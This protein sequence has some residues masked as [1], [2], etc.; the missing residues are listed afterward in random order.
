MRIDFFQPVLG[1]DVEFFLKKNNSLIGSEKFISGDKLSTGGGNFI[2][3]GVQIEIN[4]NPSYCR[5]LLA[6]HICSCFY[7]LQKKLKADKVD[8]DFSGSVMIPEEE[9]NSLSAASRQ[10]GCNPD[11]SV[12]NGNKANIKEDGALTR[13]RTAGGHLHFGTRDGVIGEF[14]F[15]TKENDKCTN[16]IMPCKNTYTYRTNRYYI[17]SLQQNKT[18]IHLLKE[19]KDLTDDEFKLLQKEFKKVFHIEL[20]EEYTIADKDNCIDVVQNPYPIIPLLDLFVGIPSVL[21]DRDEGAKERRKQYGKAG[22][23]RYQPHGIEYRTL[24]NFW[25]YSYPMMSLFFG[26]GRMAYLICAHDRQFKTHIAEDF[27]KMVDQKDIVSAINNNDYKMARDIFLKIEKSL[28]S[29]A[30]D[31]NNTDN[32]PL[33]SD[34]LN[35]FKTF[36]LNGYKSYFTESPEINWTKI[37]ENTH[38]CGW[39]SF[40]RNKIRMTKDIEKLFSE[41]ILK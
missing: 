5:A 20:P 14:I 32:F 9:F 19:R 3:D 10:F 16:C 18:N 36:V 6:D 23:F 15:K 30:D 2:K 28:V 22:D 11:F 26:L 33:A 1:M 24:S 40:S 8:V 21:I 41:T 4:P 39:E 31:S 25:L 13:K 17:T 37:T 38:Y 27:L 29:I 34:N 12:Y 35:A 7:E